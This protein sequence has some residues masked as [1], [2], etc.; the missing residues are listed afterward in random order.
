MEEADDFG[1]WFQRDKGT[2]WQGGVAAR[3]QHC[4]EGRRLT[5][6][7]FQ[8]QAAGREQAERA[9]GLWDYTLSKP[10]VNGMLLP[11][12]LTLLNVPK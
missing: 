6:H 7:I 2:S 8:P 12:K 10:T 3:G 11:A 5:V 4:G 1:A 9:A